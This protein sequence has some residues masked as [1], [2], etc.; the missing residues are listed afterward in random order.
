MLQVGLSVMH[1]EFFEHDPQDIAF[2]QS[3]GV[4]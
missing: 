3:L 1:F 2:I 4:R